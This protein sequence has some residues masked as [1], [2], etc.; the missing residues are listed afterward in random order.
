SNGSLAPDRLPPRSV[1]ENQTFTMMSGS[2]SLSLPARSRAVPLHE[3]R[4]L[5]VVHAPDRVDPKRDPQVVAARDGFVP[6]QLFRVIN[7][8][9]DGPGGDRPAWY[10]VSVL[11]DP[12]LN[13]VRALAGSELDEPEIGEAVLVKRVFLDDG[14]DLPSTGADGQDDAA[15][16]R[17]LSTLDQEV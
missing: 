6:A 2:L 13:V 9:T 11:F 14:L 1:S 8:I 10:A 15:V 3:E 17:E 12:L 7:L 16:S 5:R 4:Y